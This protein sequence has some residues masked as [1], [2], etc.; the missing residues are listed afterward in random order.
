[1]AETRRLAPVAECWAVALRKGR[2]VIAELRDDLQAARS[3]LATGDTGAAAHKLD[4]ALQRLAAHR[5]LTT[6]EA[7]Q[8]LGIRSVNTLKALVRV[9]G[10]Q[11]VMHGNRMMIPLS[12][13]ERIRESARVRGIRAADRAHDAADALGALEALTQ[14]EMDALSAGRPG[15]PPWQ[16]DR[17]QAGHRQSA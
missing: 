8:V 12:E 9:E 4:D 15:T 13:V 16:R 17:A 1:M 11:T 10:I 7:A 5:L 14:D 2:A 3:L 6:T